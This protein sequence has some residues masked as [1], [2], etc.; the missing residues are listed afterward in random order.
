VLLG[1]AKIETTTVY[2]KV[3]TR[4]IREVTSPLDL[5]VQREAGPG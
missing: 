1:H 5:L 3:A 4:M 2:T